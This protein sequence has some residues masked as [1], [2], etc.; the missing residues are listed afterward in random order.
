MGTQSAAWPVYSNRTADEGRLCT[1]HVRS[2]TSR[3]LL[4]SVQLFIKPLTGPANATVQ[5]SINLI[6]YAI[7]KIKIF[8]D[9]FQSYIVSYVHLFCV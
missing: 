1:G 9:S 6:V 7:F 8:F 2:L 3:L 5:K 4:K